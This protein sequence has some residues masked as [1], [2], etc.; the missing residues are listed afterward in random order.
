MRRHL[1]KTQSVPSKSGSVVTVAC[2][3]LLI[4]QCG[5]RVLFWKSVCGRSTARE[6]VLSVGSS[7]H[8]WRHGHRDRG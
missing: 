2:R 6:R 4:V 7:G 5:Q 8:L 1:V 3:P